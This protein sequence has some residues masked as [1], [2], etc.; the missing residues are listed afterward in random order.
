MNKKKLVLLTAAVVFTFTSF[1]Q[2]ILAPD[3]GPYRKNN[4]STK[5]N[6]TYPDVREADVMWSKRIWRVIDLREKINLPLSYPQTEIRDRRSLMDVLW[7]AVT[8]RTITPYEN[9]EFIAPKSIEQIEKSA[10]AGMYQ[11]TLIRPDPPYEPFDTLIKREFSTESVIQYRIK[12]DWFFDKQRSVMDVRIIGI[13]PIVYATDDQ[14]NIREGGETKPLFWIYFPEARWLLAKEEAFNRQN[15]AQRLSYDDIFQKRLFNSYVM[16]E[17]NVYDRR[18]SEYA[19]GI[20]ALQESDRI[21]E[22]IINFE[23]DMWEY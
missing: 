13:A 17:S 21:K 23:H 14:G 8:E 16:K 1:A 22:M 2:S 20:R 3:D 9:D 5:T 15:D 7:A 6:M 4:M 19:T 18:I 11:I 12:E 10:G